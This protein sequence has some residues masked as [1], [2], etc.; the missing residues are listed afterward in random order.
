MEALTSEGIGPPLAGSPVSGNVPAM[1][2]IGATA[3]H[4]PVHLLET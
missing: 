1:A 4:A 2:T 3:V